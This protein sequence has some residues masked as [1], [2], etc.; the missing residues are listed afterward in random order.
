[1]KLIENIK[2]DGTK[3]DK[4]AAMYYKT[5]PFVSG[6]GNYHHTNNWEIKKSIEILNRK[7]FSVDLIDRTNNNW[8]PRKKFDLF[9]GLGVGNTGDKFVK[10]AK[11]SQAKKRVL[12]AMGPQPDVSNSRTIERYKMFNKRTGQNA[13]PMRT[14]TKVLGKVF[15][16]IIMHT[17]YIFCIGEKGTASYN[18]FKQYNKPILSFY[19]A[20]SDKVSFKRGWLQTRKR[21]HFLCF[22]GN[23]LICKG[24]DVVLES[25]VNQ[26]DKFLHICGPQEPAFMS[27]YS[28][29]ISNSE[30]IFYHGFVTP[31]GDRFNK[32]S[33]LCSYVIFHASAEGCC[34][35]VATAMKAGLVPIIN[36]WTGV[37]IKDGVN[38][39]SIKEGLPL[40]ENINR[41][42]EDASKIS[43]REYELM[44][45]N[46][47]INSENYSQS[48]FI[49]SYT[50]C[51]NEVI[52]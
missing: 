23:G 14:V 18:S 30:N 9:L 44:V 39:I 43:K 36:P 29:T 26:K 50:K 28:K 8:N 42:V 6:V 34:T 24:V 37:I 20:I 21:N 27:Q 3:V 22:A 16:E 32:I 7:G 11:R 52:S 35:S 17:D 1:M 51:I 2:L 12:L 5:E 31:G 38:G 13:P 47:N 45:T 4:T 46:N 41:K 10:Y 49:K 33:Q 25:F 40:I 15:E 19:P 48:G